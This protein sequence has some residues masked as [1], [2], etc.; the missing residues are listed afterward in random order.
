MSLTFYGINFH[1]VIKKKGNIT[2]FLL[3]SC[4]FVYVD[5]IFCLDN[6]EKK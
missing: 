6:V 2:S 1:T 5:N 4:I 3:D